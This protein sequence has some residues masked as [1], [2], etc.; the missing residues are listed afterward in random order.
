MIQGATAFIV[1]AT[2]VEIEGEISSSI[3][4]LEKRFHE[5]VKHP[6]SV[7]HPVFDLDE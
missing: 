4:D 1:S 7:P 3:G 2:T 5:I 6:L